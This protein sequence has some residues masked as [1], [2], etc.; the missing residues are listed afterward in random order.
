MLTVIH[1]KSSRHCQYE[2]HTHTLQFDQSQSET[3][4]TICSNLAAAFFATYFTIKALAG[5]QRA[6][7]RQ[8]RGRRSAK[9]RDTGD[10]PE[11]IPVIPSLKTRPVRGHQEAH[12]NTTSCEL[13]GTQ[14]TMTSSLSIENLGVFQWF[15]RT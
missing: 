12:P 14:E 10:T 8:T 13:L 3:L 6:D 1:W 9:S 5:Q 15:K 4:L 7:A 2:T 11:V